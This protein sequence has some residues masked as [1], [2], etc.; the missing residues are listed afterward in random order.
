MAQYL[1][2]AEGPYTAAEMRLADALLLSAYD[3]AAADYYCGVPLQ[4]SN[5]CW[6]DFGN[7]YLR[8]VK[9]RPSSILYDP[10]PLDFSGNDSEKKGHNH[11]KGP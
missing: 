8:Q 10:V 6:K 4:D 1:A 5:S 7:K 2:A 9:E 3:R 11:H